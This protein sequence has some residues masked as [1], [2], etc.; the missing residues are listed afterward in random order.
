MTHTE[1][2]TTVAIHVLIVSFP[3]SSHIA[4]EK[5]EGAWYLIIYWCIS[6]K[7]AYMKANVH[8]IELI[9]SV[10]RPEAVASQGHY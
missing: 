9:D 6:I 3:G 8:I 2:V 1:K 4:A 5:Q 10:S 7:V